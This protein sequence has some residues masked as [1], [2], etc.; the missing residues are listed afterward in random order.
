MSA[1]R[2]NG[3]VDSVSTDPARG[4]DPRREDRITRT[5]LA[6]IS[7]PTI[8]VGR[9]LEQSTDH[10]E[11]HTILEILEARGLVELPGDGTIAV[12]PPEAALT[13]FAAEIERQARRMRASASHMG[14][15]HRRARD[16]DQSVE[17]ELRAH[18]LGSLGEIRAATAEIVSGAEQSIL[19]AR[20]DSARTRALLASEADHDS[21]TTSSA[22]DPLEM[23][24]VYDAALL[25]VP[26]VIDVLRRRQA[27]GEQ[28]HLAH[29]IPFSVIVVD[30]QAGVL[31]LS[32]ITDEGEGSARLTG[33]PL[34]S[35]LRR[36]VRRL[37]D[38]G[39]PLP[40]PRGAR[41]RVSGLTER[42]LVVLTMLA[43]GT[44]DAVAARQLGVSVRTVERRVRHIMDVLGTSSRLQT[45]IEAARRE[46]V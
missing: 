26:G 23:I 40:D 42:D 3:G 34:V 31:D 27:A 22:G 5:Y 43:A 8:D 29:D 2:Q 11:A 45:G 15:V 38:D 37:H 35:A 16:T 32:S 7:D 12:P 39:L 21:P 33:G 1:R 25:E 9:Y 19:V 18:P 41:E 20:A 46:I 28:V 4:L 14:M 17:I 10:E 36:Y 13:A 6:F 24:A 44:S 30:D